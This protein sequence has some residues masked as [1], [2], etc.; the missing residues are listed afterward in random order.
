MSTPANTVFSK[1]NLTLS[2]T[3]CL[4]TIATVVNL[5][6]SVVVVLLDMTSASDG[7]SHRGLINK[8]KSFSITEPTLSCL[9]AHLS[10]RSQVVRVCGFTFHFR[11]VNRS[12]IQGSVLGPLWFLLYVDDASNVVGNDI[13]FP[14]ISDIKT[15]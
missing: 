6:E 9:T 10:S 5:G 7:V 15:V 2:V 11:P 4:N 13:F 8:I 14:F 3:G 1:R 12:A